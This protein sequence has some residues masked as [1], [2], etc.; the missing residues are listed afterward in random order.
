MPTKVELAPYSADWQVIAQHETL[1]LIQALKGLIIEVHH[2]GSTAIPGIHAKPIIDLMPVVRGLGELDEE[3]SVFRHFGYRYRGENGIVGRRY[4]TFNEPSTG[5]R[6]YQVHCFAS[7]S[8][9]I[10][11][12]LAFRDYMRAHPEKALE[13][14]TEKR[15]CREL[16]PEDSHAYSDAKADWITGVLPAALAHFARQPK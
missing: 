10:E 2:I 15:R 16:H 4:C 8:R 3:E 5:R 13:Y 14:E 11:R 12:H 9:E 1:R 6:R 7:G